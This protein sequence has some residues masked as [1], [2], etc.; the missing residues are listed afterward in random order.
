MRLQHLFNRVSILFEKDTGD[1]FSLMN[2]FTC[3]QA[4][5]DTFY[6]TRGAGIFHLLVRLISLIPAGCLY[7]QGAQVAKTQMTKIMLCPNTINAVRELCVH[8]HSITP[9]LASQGELSTVWDVFKVLNPSACESVKRA[10]ELVVCAQSLQ[11]ASYAESVETLLDKVGSAVQV[12]ETY[13]GEEKYGKDFGCITYALGLFIALTASGADSRDSQY[14]QSMEVVTRILTR[15]TPHF[16]VGASI[17]SEASWR[18]PTRLDM[19]ALHQLWYHCREARASGDPADAH[20]AL[21]GGGYRHRLYLRR[22]HGW[23]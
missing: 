2:I 4:G 10:H 15:A 12:V 19:R 17:R 5:E 18:L 3:L 1:Q 7:P 8:A 22:Q 20:A 23:A 13:T 16:R 9:L 21:A 11:V 14:L 6:H